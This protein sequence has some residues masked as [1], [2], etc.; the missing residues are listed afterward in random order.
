MNDTALLAADPTAWDPSPGMSQVPIDG[1]VWIARNRDGDGPPPALEAPAPLA[2]LRP[3]RPSGEVLASMSGAHRAAVLLL[4]LGLDTAVKVIPLMKDEEVEAVSVEIARMKNVP[5]EEV[6][7]VLAEYR[8]LALA[9]AYV[10]QGGPTLARQMLSAALGDDR[11]EE[12]LMKVEA[13]MEVSAF[14]LLHTVDSGRLVD[15]LQGEHPQ[16][17]ALILTQLNP[18]K[19]GELIGKL[20]PDVQ[21]EVAYRIA[22]MTPPA[23]EVLR[24]VEEVIRQQIG[25]VLGATATGGGGIAKVA[26]ILVSAGR[27]AERAVMEALKLR[28]PELAATVKGLMFVFD[29]LVFLDGRDL[30]KVLAS[31]DARDLALALKAA[32]EDLQKKVF[33]NVSERAGQSIRDETALLGSV[34]VSEVDEAQGRVLEAA[35]ELEGRGEIVLARTGESPALL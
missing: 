21:G 24:E 30:Q 18:R 7:A 28:A 32:P 5:G 20:T 8:D 19:A 34:R 15:L 1:T 6:E 10:T 3:P 27:T 22:T 29:D 35:Q 31:V 16:T 12:V 2:S 25:A 9:R 26:E 11:A 23:P 4:A 17:A 33:Q 13:A 14:H